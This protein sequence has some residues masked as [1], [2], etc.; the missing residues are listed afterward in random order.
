VFR[1][2]RLSDKFAMEDA[3]EKL[4]DAANML[5]LLRADGRMRFFT[6]AS[7]PEPIAGDTVISYSPPDPGRAAGK[8]SP[9]KAA[10]AQ[11]A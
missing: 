3:K 8:R 4:P 5:L 9:A 11:P 7:A 2:T 10:K 6:H 1:K